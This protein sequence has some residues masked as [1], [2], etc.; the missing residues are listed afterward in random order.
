M[1]NKTAVIQLNTTHK[2]F[3]CNVWK[4]HP[5]KH[6]FIFGENYNLCVKQ[7]NVK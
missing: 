5:V 7:Q 3:I 4:I 1:E 2:Y 6:L